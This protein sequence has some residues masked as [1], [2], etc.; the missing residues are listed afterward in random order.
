MSL[1]DSHIQFHAINTMNAIFVDRLNR[2]AVHI[3]QPQTKLEWLASILK[4]IKYKF[5][6]NTWV[7]KRCILLTAPLQ[8]SNM[9]ETNYE[10][11]SMYDIM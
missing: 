11:H 2:N 4:K 9:P 8:R 10:S 1:A 3:Q 7:C 6:W 5:K